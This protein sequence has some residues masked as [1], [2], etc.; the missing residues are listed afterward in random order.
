MTSQEPGLPG[1]DLDQKALEALVVDNPDLERLEALLSQFNIFEAIGAVR[2][3]SRHSDFLAYLL[4]PKQNHGL[5]DTFLKRLLQKALGSAGPG[6]V[7]ITPIDLD[8]WN[9]DDTIVQREWQNIDILVLNEANRLAVIIENKVGSSESPGQLARYGQAVSQHYPGWH[10]L[11]L[12]LT[13]EGDTAS[14][15]TFLAIDYGLVCEL[16]EGLSETRASTLGA[17]VHTI[18]VH[19]AQMLRRHIMS[20]SEIAQLCRRIYQK[21][22][23]ALDLIYGFRP[24]RQEGIR[25]LLQSLIQQLPSLVLDESNKRYVRFC[26]AVWDVPVLLEG[27]DWTRS[28]RVLLFEF[29]N[30]PE[31][32]ILRLVIG[33]GPDETRQ[34]LFNMAEAN[35][36]LFRPAFRTLNQKWN[37][38]FQREFLARNSYEDA[39]LNQLD[40]KIRKQWEKFIESDLP[41]IQ[42]VLKAEIWLWPEEGAEA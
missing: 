4:S 14:D 21:H 1:A 35:R 39:D 16:I 24:D 8:V 32:L 23:R 41:A 28:G 37:T 17:D 27:D 11:G 13:P 9:L 20:E 2:Q 10:L 34:R 7:P 22:Q 5:G 40:G 36:P 30:D 29:V 15:E 18:M 38:I 19:Y 12:Y 25:G 6:T 42:A 26:L 31:R 33:P 3:E